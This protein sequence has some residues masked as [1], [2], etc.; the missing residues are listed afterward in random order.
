[1]YRLKFDRVIGE[2]AWGTV[3]HATNSS[4]D[5]SYAVKIMSK[6]SLLKE[7]QQDHAHRERKILPKLDHPFIVKF[8]RFYQDAR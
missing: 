4:G 7:R 8:E 2:G 5:K 3:W 6:H 1:M